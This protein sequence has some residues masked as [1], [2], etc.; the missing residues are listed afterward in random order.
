METNSSLLILLQRKH[1]DLKG[2]EKGGKLGRIEGK[3]KKGFSLKEA[4]T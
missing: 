2:E 1:V 4:S 3:K